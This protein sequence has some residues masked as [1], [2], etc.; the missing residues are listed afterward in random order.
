MNKSRFLLP[1]GFFLATAVAD[2]SAP[3]SKEELAE[4]LNGVEVSD[5][6]ESP[7]DGV[8]QVAVGSNVAY[9]T[10]DGRYLIQGELYDLSTSENLTEVSRSKARVDMLGSVE[11]DEMIVF[12]PPDGE[13]KHTI[14]IFTD[15]DCGYCRQFHREIEQVNALGIEVHYLF[16]PRTGPDTESWAKADKVW[17]ASDRNTALTRAKLGGEVPDAEC[18]ETPVDEHF[19][20]GNMVG[21]RGTPAVFA[22]NGELL[23]GYLPPQTLAARLEELAP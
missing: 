12:S 16:Y 8:Y 10:A 4:K 23:G 18:E 15:I 9:V 22:E 17:C 14:T 7:L 13:V 20:L 3:L 6:T 19:E 21:V 1:L 11:R 5:I 2:E